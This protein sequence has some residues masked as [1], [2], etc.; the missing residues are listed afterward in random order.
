MPKYF[1]RA[2]LEQQLKD[3]H[4]MLI[5]ERSRANLAE[6]RLHVA[7]REIAQLNEAIERGYKREASLSRKVLKQ[8]RR[9]AQQERRI[10][11]LEDRLTPYL[12][13]E[14]LEEIA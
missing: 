3:L 4:A 12:V 13:K 11:E 14:A 6:M 10:E 5:G 2:E 8:E 7:K 1:N 9:I